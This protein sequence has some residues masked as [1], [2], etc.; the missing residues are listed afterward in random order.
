MLPVNE[1]AEAARARFVGTTSPGLVK[2]TTDFLFKD[3]WL[4][5]DLEPRDRSLVTISSLIANGQA[6]QLTSHLTLGMNNGLT[7]REISEVI[8]HAAFYA[9]WPNAFSAMAVA[10]GV[11]EAQAK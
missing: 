11:F 9:G 5:P 4:R 2:D 6:A 7:Q 1:A 10:K 3:L 8:S